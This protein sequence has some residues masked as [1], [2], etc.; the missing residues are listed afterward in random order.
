MNKEEYRTRLDSKWW[1]DLAA[2]LKDFVQNTCQICG[3]DKHALHIHHL[4]YNNL[5]NNKEY[6]DMV[7]VCEGCHD[8]YHSVHRLPPM[9][10]FSREEKL[11]HFADT[12][13]NKGIDTH[14]F[15]KNGATGIRIWNMFVPA[16]VD[17]VDKKDRV[18][19]AKRPKNYVPPERAFNKIA[20]KKTPKNKKSAWK[21]HNRPAKFKASEHPKLTRRL[22]NN[23]KVSDKEL[24]RA[25]GLVQ[26]DLKK[27]W[28]KRIFG[29]VHDFRR[30]LEKELKDLDSRS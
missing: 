20:K 11:A 3:N 1:K 18:F 28:K 6:E 14:Y 15:L 13:A 22:L 17:E 12:V 9:G 4:S 5:G 21:G 8:T 7:V 30:I 25:F 16:I 10:R 27:G 23:E 19:K 24:I 2:E 29:F 26:K